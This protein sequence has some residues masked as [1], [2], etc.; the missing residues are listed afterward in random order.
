MKNI[1]LKIRLLSL[2]IMMIIAGKVQAQWINPTG[3]QWNVYGKPTS[4]SIPSCTFIY[5]FD[6][7]YAQYEGYIYRL[8]DS[9][10][11]FLD[12]LPIGMYRE[13]NGKIFM[14]EI[15]Y[16]TMTP[17][18]EY[19]IYDWNLNIGETVYVQHGSSLKGLIL[20]AITETV[21]NGEER[22]VFNLHYEDDNALTEIWIE[23]M[24]SELG[25]PF[26][27]TKNN[28]VSFN[29]FPMTTEMLCYYEDG[30]QIWDNPDYDECV[31]DYVLDVA[32]Q[33]ENSSLIVYPNPATD[34]LS[35][36]TY[37][38]NCSSVEIFSLDGRLVKAPSANFNAIDISSLASGLYIIKVRTKD[39]RECIE[40]ILKE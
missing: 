24:G 34:I 30:E 1:A 18:E 13:D 27:G 36:V 6:N 38:V 28:P 7:R 22:R 26:S 33:D 29:Y 23:G 32:E 12:D 40:R 19:L 35:I 10:S 9:P 39:G 37:D 15:N 3:Q 20:D 21:V 11:D 5:Y 31:K 17:S 25:F 16:M 8:L 2:L 14:R 4:V